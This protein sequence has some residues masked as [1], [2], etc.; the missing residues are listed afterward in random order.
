MKKIN[1]IN[2]ISVIVVI[3]ILLGFIRNFILDEPLSIFKEKK[4]LN[5]IDGVI[6]PDYLDEPMSINIDLAYK[7]FTNNSIFIDARDPSDFSKERILNSI[8]ISYDEVENYEDIILDLDPLKPVVIYCSGGECEL[9]MHL[10]DILFDE[11]EFEKV[12]IFEDGFPAWKK[13]GYPIEWKIFYYIKKQI[14]Y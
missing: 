3:S 9:S 14:L 6:I 12:L 2:E 7:L 5:N 10:G 8:N 13:S 4:I 11:Y 1:Y